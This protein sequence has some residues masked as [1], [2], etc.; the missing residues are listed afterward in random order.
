[1]DFLTASLVL[2]ITLIMGLFMILFARLRRDRPP[3]LR[4]L[5]G[6]RAL[7]NQ[8]GRA[9]E[10]GRQIHF[11]LGHGGLHQSSS[12]TSL[13]ALTTLDHLAARSSASTAPPF[14]TV[15]ESTLLLAGQ[16]SVRQ[17]YRQSGRAGEI[18]AA[19][20]QFLAD[21]AYPMTYAAA[22]NDLI[23]SAHIGSSILLGRFGPEIAII[24]EAGSR[25]Q[26]AQIIGSDDPQAIA[27]ATTVTED[28]LV[29]EEMLAAGAYLEGK[30]AQVASLQAQ[31][32][33]RWLAAL[34]VLG[35]ALVGLWGGG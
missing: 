15:N 28:V 25:R 32:V 2:I 35:S 23:H 20:V 4:P 3:D 13:A 9:V 21:S 24:T 16:D 7:V 26:V 10:S 29:G 17:A 27:L 11:G 19:P 12:A 1:M 31:D 5:R 34:A 30:P 14:V 33:M 8:V 22:A 18:A 6:Y